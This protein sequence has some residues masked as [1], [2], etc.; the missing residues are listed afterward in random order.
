MT[1]P[2]DRVAKA[3]KARGWSIRTAAQNGGI[4]NQT[5]GVFEGGGNI[6]PAIQRAVMQAFDWPA[7]WVERDVEAVSSRSMPFGAKWQNYGSS[8]LTWQREPCCRMTTSCRS[9]T[10]IELLNRLSDLGHQPLT[11]GLRGIPPPRTL[12]THGVEPRNG[13]S[14]RSPL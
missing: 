6:T 9:T 8:S 10:P 13:V 7:D 12:S 1:T 5:W 11:L 14:H 2:A 4:S 3:R